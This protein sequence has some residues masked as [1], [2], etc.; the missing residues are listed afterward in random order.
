MSRKSWL[1]LALF[2][3]QL[4][5]PN[6]LQSQ[7]CSLDLSFDPGLNSSANVYVMALQTNGQILLGGAFNSVSNVP[8]TNVARLN[9]DG[10]LDASFDPG[11]AA[12]VGYVT[13]IAVQD[14]GKVLIGGFFSS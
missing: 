12:D 11:P 13:A 8:R 2:L 7:P 9:P 14:D 5:M 3:A 1:C 10:T 4:G 6:G